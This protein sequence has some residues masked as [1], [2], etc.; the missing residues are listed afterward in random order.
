MKI[1]VE[2][3]KDGVT[4]LLLQHCGTWKTGETQAIEMAWEETSF[5]VSNILLGVMNVPL[6]INNEKSLRDFSLALIYY[7]NANKGTNLK[8][9]DAIK[10]ASSIIF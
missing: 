10:L 4:D 9:E 1:N 2:S 6:P 5:G 8:M 3:L 7:I